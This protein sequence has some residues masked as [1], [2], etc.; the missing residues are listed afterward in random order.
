M[1][2]AVRASAQGNIPRGHVALERLCCCPGNDPSRPNARTV[3]HRVHCCRGSNDAVRPPVD[4]RSDSEQLPAGVE[5]LDRDRRS[6]AR[7]PA[8]HGHPEQLRLAGDPLRRQR[9][10]PVLLVAE[11][12]RDAGSTPRCRGTPRSSATSRTEAVEREGQHRGPHLRAEPATLE[13]PPEPRTGVDRSVDG[14]LRRR[15]P[16]G[17]PIGCAIQLDHQVQLPGI[18]RPVR[19]QCPSGAA[20]TRARRPGWARSTRRPRTASR[21]AGGCRP[22]RRPSAAARSSSVGRRRT[23][24]SLR[25]R[26]PKSGQAS[27]RVEASAVMGARRYTPPMGAVETMEDF[28]EKLNARR[29]R[30]RGRPDGR[31]DRDARPRRRQRPDP[32]RRRA[33]RRLVP[34]RRRRACR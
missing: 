7:P 19:A 29:S 21:R 25:M 26:S 12:P 34:A 30:G 22:W 18:G 32:A 6:R 1:D 20:G 24:R 31:E 16:T 13:R 11:R 33:R 5:P 23:S 8:L 10:S 14:E 27:V 2:G 3:R 17:V 15:A 9:A 4:G 28:F